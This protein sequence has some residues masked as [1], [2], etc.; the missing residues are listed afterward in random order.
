MVNVLISHLDP[1]LLYTYN[2]YII[3]I[4]IDCD[5]KISIRNLGFTRAETKVVLIIEYRDYY[6]YTLARIKKEKKELFSSLVL[7]FLSSTLS[8]LLPLSEI[9]QRQ[10]FMKEEEK[11][12]NIKSV[13]TTPLRKSPPAKDGAEFRTRER[14]KK[15]GQKS[16]SADAKIRVY[17][18]WEGRSGYT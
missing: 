6:D 5:I 8:S 17:R 9:N 14:G 18:G 13:G 15:L 11:K 7:L 2:T 3:S 12:R 1:C 4:S 10:R 16:W